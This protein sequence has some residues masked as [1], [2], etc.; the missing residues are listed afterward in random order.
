MTIQIPSDQFQPNH[1]N[2][3]PSLLPPHSL[4]LPPLSILHNT[5]PHPYS[6]LV[7]RSSYPHILLLHICLRIGHGHTTPT[8]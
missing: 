3:S 7:R 1:T 8:V 4:M 2:P 6:P 5:H